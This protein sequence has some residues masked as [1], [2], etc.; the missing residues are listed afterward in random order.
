MLLEIAHILSSLITFT[1]PETYFHLIPCIFIWFS[2]PNKP[3]LQSTIGVCFECPLFV[4]LMCFHACNHVCLFMLPYYSKTYPCICACMFLCHPT[5]FQSFML[6][7]LFPKISKTFW[8]LIIPSCVSHA[9][10]RISMHVSR[11][12]LG[13]ISYA[14]VVI[15][16]ILNITYI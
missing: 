8:Y 5:N 1:E 11:I 4:M 16:T 10:S 2:K 6:C 15:S 9:C 12:Y 14:L 3:G 7:T 13:T